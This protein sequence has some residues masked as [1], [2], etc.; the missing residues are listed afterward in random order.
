MSAPTFDQWKDRRR[1]ELRIEFMRDIDPTKRLYGHEY[2][3]WLRAK[4]A[5]E[6]PH[7]DSAS[8]G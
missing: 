7:T 1:H 4:Y 8:E 6:F 5:T 3:A 2:E